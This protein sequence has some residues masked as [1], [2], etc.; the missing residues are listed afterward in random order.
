MG[1][2]AFIYASKY[3]EQ[4]LLGTAV[5]GPMTFVVYTFVKLVREVSFKCRTGSWVKSKNSVWITDEGKIRWSSL[6]PLANYTIS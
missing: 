4:G 3:S 2:G 1:T 5:L 6:I